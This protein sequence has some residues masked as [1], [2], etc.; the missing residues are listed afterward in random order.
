VLLLAPF[1]LDQFLCID[2]NARLPPL[3][4]MD[5]LRKFDQLIRVKGETDVRKVDRWMSPDILPVLPENRTF[6]SKDYVA[7]W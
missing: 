2:P 6:R 7:Y 4:A 1:L 3:S 5:A